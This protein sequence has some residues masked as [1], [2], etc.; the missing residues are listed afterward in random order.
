MLFFE[1]IVRKDESLR[2]LEAELEA[3]KEKQREAIEQVWA[4]VVALEIRASEHS[5]ESWW[6]RKR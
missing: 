1:Q 3:I 5:G 4:H 6:S 2:L